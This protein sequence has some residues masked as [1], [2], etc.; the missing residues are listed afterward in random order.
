[1]TEDE[2]RKVIENPKFCTAI[3][4]T[5]ELL[6]AICDWESKREETLNSLRDIMRLI[7]E[8]Y[9]KRT[10]AKVSGASAALVGSG[11]AIVGFGLAFVT[12]GASLALSVV[13]GVIAAS[14]G[15]TMV[16]ADIGDWL[17]SRGQMQTAKTLIDRDRERS[18]EI[19]QRAQSLFEACGVLH[20]EYPSLS[21][22]N[23]LGLISGVM[24]GVYW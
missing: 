17:V 23:I 8:S 24:R 16:G 22:E 11:V 21:K 14:G 19:K 7:A 9:Q 1:M 20:R 4:A 18:A 10:I 6:K 2:A 13:G 12:F 3:K 15:A 5:E